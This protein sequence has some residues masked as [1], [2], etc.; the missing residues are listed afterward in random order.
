MKTDSSRQIKIKICGLTIPDQA[1]SCFEMGADLIGLN[2]W[3]GSPR[4]IVP[5]I[6]SEIVSELPKSSKTVGVFVN[7]SPDSINNLIPLCRECHTKTDI[8]REFN[9]QL[10]LIVERRING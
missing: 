6:I 1:V 5:E 10:K 2:C 8:D 7:E 4:Y 9:E 3:K